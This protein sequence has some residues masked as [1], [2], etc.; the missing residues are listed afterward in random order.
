M[1]LEDSGLDYNDFDFAL[2]TGIGSISSKYK[3]TISSGRVIPLR[4]TLCGLT[5]IKNKYKNS[6]YEVIQD[7]E[8]TN[9]SSAAKIFFKLIKGPLT[10]MLVNIRYKGD[11]KS[12]P[13][14]QAS[15]TKDFKRLL[16]QETCNGPG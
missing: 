4:T 16:D 8:S 9:S 7:V 5:R 6:P 1:E 14:F 15:M 12:Q 3:V 10:I 11:F 2:V 13:Q